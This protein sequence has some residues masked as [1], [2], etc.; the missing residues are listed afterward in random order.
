M[1]NLIDTHVMLDIETLGTE[2]GSVIFAI[3]ATTFDPNKKYVEIKDFD[4]EDVLLTA[5]DIEQ[6]LE[7]GFKVNGNT[8]HFWLSQPPEASEFLRGMEQCSPWAAM[9]TLDRYLRKQSLSDLTIWANGITFDCVLLEAYYSKLELPIPWKYKYN[10]WRDA[11]TIYRTFGQNVPQY[12]FRGVP[13]NP[14]HDCFNQVI[15][16]NNVFDHHKER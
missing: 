5:I 8:M 15:K 1:R 13:H 16:L 7:Q 10:C 3:A 2:P 11:R 6:S 12:A 14:L 4:K 9:E